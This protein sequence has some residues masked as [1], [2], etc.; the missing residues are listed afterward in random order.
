ME[1]QSKPVE[2]QWRKAQQNNLLPPGKASHWKSITIVGGLI[3]VLVGVFLATVFWFRPVSEISF[4]SLAVHSY[5]SRQMPCIPFANKDVQVFQKKHLISHQ[6]NSININPSGHQFLQRL[7]ELQSVQTPVVLYVIA[8]ARVNKRGNLHILCSDA[9]PDNEDSGIRIQAFLDRLDACPSQQIL[10]LLDLSQEGMT[11]RTGTLSND[12]ATVLVKE[13][14]KRPPENV[15]LFLSCSPGQSSY[16]SEALGRSVFSYYLEKGLNGFADGSLGSQKLDGRV[17]VRELAHYVTTQV[18]QF[19]YHAR[20]RRQTPLL[21]GSVDDFPLRSY[22]QED[23]SQ[24]D[25]TLPKLP[26]YPKWLKNR[27]EIVDTENQQQ[28]YQ[29]SPHMFRQRQATVL[30]AEQSWRGGVESGT[31]MANDQV[32]WQRS[33]KLISQHQQLP[34]PDLH[35][36]TLDRAF[37]KSTTKIP[38]DAIDQLVGQILS[39]PKTGKPGD[40]EKAQ[41]KLVSDFLKKQKANKNALFYGLFLKATEL[42]GDDLQAL[43]VLQMVAQKVQGQSQAPNW[44]ELQILYKLSDMVNQPGNESQLPAIPMMFDVTDK[45]E[46]VLTKVRAFPWIQTALTRTEQERYEGEFRFWASDYLATTDTKSQL[47]LANTRLTQTLTQANA[48]ENAYEVL[49]Q[50][51]L[52]LADYVPYLQNHPDE[53]ITWQ[54]ALQQCSKLK[55]SLKTPK[56]VPPNLTVTIQEISEAAKDLETS[57]KQLMQPFS[58]ANIKL[59]VERSQTPQADPKLWWSMQAVLSVPFLNVKDRTE[60]WK[61]TLQLDRTI[62]ERALQRESDGDNESL[63]PY[64][65]DFFEIQQHKEAILHAQQQIAILKLA[66]APDESLANLTNELQKATKE[67]NAANVLY[68]IAADIARI[69]GQELKQQ[70]AQSKA[71]EDKAWLVRFLPPL[72]DPPSTLFKQKL[73]DNGL[74]VAELQQALWSN[75][76]DRFQYQVWDLRNSGVVQ[77]ASLDSLAEFYAE[78]S[79]EYADLGKLQPLDN[80]SFVGDSL[81]KKEVPQAEFILRV[82]RNNSTEPKFRI[83]SP[84]TKQLAFQPQAGQTSLRKQPKKNSEL[85]YYAFKTKI[86]WPTSDADNAPQIPGF[87]VEAFDESRSFHQLITIP[88]RSGSQPVQIL[89]SSNPVKPDPLV[90]NVRLRPSGVQQKVF[91]HLFNADKKERKVNAQLVMGEEIVDGSQTAVTLPPMVT[92]PVK[93]TSKVPLPKKGLPSLNGPL[94]I[95][96]YADNSNTL[97]AKKDIPVAVASPREYVTVSKIRY[98]ASPTA[99]QTSNLLEADLQMLTKISGPDVPVELELPKERM[100]GLL[101]VKDGTFKGKLKAS[102]QGEPMP[103]ALFAKGIEFEPGEERQ[104]VIY[105]NADGYPRAFIYKTSFAYRN[106]PVTP[107]IEGKP[108]LRFRADPLSRAQKDYLVHVEV[109][110]PPKDSRL[111]LQLGE[112]R[113]GEFQADVDQIYPKA[114][115][116][117]VGFFVDAKSGGLLFEGS[118]S[119]RIIPIDTTKVIG[120]RQLRARLLDTTGLELGRASM[121]II[122]DTTPPQ[123]VTFLSVP[124]KA[125][126]GSVVTVSANGVDPE[127][128]IATV[129]FFFGRPMKGKIPDKIELMPAKPLPNMGAAWAGPVYFP[130][131]KVGPISLSVRFTN[132]VGLTTFATAEIDLLAKDPNKNGPGRIVGT[133]A[134]GDLKQAGLPVYLYDEKNKPLSQTKTNKDGKFE[135]DNL[136]PGKYVVYCIKRASQRRGYQRVTVHANRVSQTQITL[137]LGG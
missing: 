69:F 49:D 136:K 6:S 89:L 21:L 96:V 1:N 24:F 55:K 97:L 28:W 44:L 46:S 93:F 121:N 109:D 8:R 40:V 110:N 103:L 16:N 116:E 30:R 9:N 53:E 13:W 15:F 126:S 76:A 85:R 26:V 133:V 102:W 67:E 61:A 123:Q 34:L 17:L 88:P 122:I 70:Y 23:K 47:E 31:I 132:K 73:G 94:S 83:F 20:N 36:L 79:G 100:P 18:D 57:I 27:W 117:T 54:R 72:D 50:A 106:E 127:S 66:Q 11:P 112:I 80:V 113:G 59:M 58:T 98:Y 134:Q 86:T 32:L 74:F 2:P 39:I 104:G 7:D 45:G 99:L 10:V 77:L 29:L 111:Q 41:A 87:L 33:G 71:I 114:K 48:L 108:A 105:I 81:W 75:L 68:K 78:A 56:G 64:E 37:H 19:T 12:V 62:T 125:V 63:P 38:R 107:L 4:V 119:D 90:A 101:S 82:I 128:G 14:Q 84:D 120:P 95:Q 130:K 60:L 135:F 91:V 51:S 124:S 5:D 35:S 3:L 115:Q 42:Q 92:V 43:P 22:A 65:A 52:V 131:D 137:K 118:I 129:D 25:S